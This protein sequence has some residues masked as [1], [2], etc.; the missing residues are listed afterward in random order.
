MKFKLTLE[1]FNALPLAQAESELLACCGSKAWAKEMLTHRPF[2][3]L[4]S[5]YDTAERVWRRLSEKDWLEAFSHHPKIGAKITPNTGNTTTS[6]WAAEEQKGTESAS[7][8]VLN[9]LHDG[10]R[11][12]EER[13]GYVFLVCATGKSAPEMLGLLNQRLKNEAGPELQI[14]AGEQAKITRIRLE[15]LLS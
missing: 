4:G 3:S 2:L 8:D 7:E 11:A 1:A 5:L 10:N 6:A 14:A 15:K 12:Y 13:F 9:R